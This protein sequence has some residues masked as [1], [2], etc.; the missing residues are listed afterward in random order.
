MFLSSLLKDLLNLH[1]KWKCE[2]KL[3]NFFSLIFNGY[4]KI[5]TNVGGIRDP[6]KKD[7]ADFCR[8][9]KTKT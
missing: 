8:N 7:L 3:G 9:T 4:S 1:Y 6:L 2:I 5:Y